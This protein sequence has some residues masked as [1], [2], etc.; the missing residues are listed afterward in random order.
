MKAIILAAG[1]GK[2]LWEVTQ[3]RP[4]C[5]IEIG[6]RSLLR[7]YLESLAAV[8]IRRADIV[9]GYKQE[10]IRAA[11]AAESCGVAVTFVVNE[12][13]HRG[14]ISSLWIARSAFDDDTVVMDADVLFHREILGRL[15]SSPF[16]N[17]LLMDETVKQTGEECMVVVAGGRVIA[18]TKK[19]PDHYD[20][21]GE[22]VGFLRVRHADAPRVVSSL[23]GYIEKNMWHMEYEDALLE[24]FH[25]VRVGHEKIGGLPWTE[26]DFVEDVKKAELEVLPKL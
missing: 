4:K 1:I 26:I 18:L 11:V 19:M 2:R 10:M 23:R 15:V 6:G 24:Y 16:G 8:G 21:A 13:F 17:A 20:Y 12:E 9:V 25:D 3:H 7:R 5:L 14:S 22:G